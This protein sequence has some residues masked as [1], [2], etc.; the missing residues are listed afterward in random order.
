MVDV[1][2][3]L[4]AAGARRARRRAHRAA[5][6]PRPT[7]RVLW[8]HVTAS[9]VLRRRRHA[10]APAGRVEDVSERHRLRSRLRGG[11]LRRTSSPG[12]P[13]RRVAE[14][15]LHRAFAAGG[16]ARVGVCT[17][18]LD[19][20]HAD[21]RRARP[22]D[23]RP[24]AAR[25]GRAAAARGRRA[26]GHAAPAPTSSS[27]WSPSPTAPRDVSR[28]AD[29]L[30]AAL[31]PPFHDR[32]AHRRRS[33]PASGSPRRATAAAERRRAAARRR[34]RRG[35]GRRRS[36]A[37]GAWCST[38]S[39]TP[40]RRPGSRCS[41]GCAGRSTAASSG[42]STSRSCGWPT[43]GCAASRRSCAGSTPSRG[44][45]GPGRFIELAE[46]SGAIVPLGRWV[47]DGGLRAG[48]GAG[49]ASWA[50][51]RPY[52]SVNVSPGPA[53][54]AGLGARGHRR[55]GR[56]R[57]A[58]RTSSSWRSPSRRCSATRPAAA[59]R[60]DA[61]CARPASGSRSTTSAPATPA[62]PGC[63]G[64]RCTR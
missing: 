52:V 22:A 57:P 13:T 10:V 28:L 56:H 15:W 34:R 31:A 36:A 49:G 40:A 9:L 64:S 50:T 24:A 38:R 18:D 44:C 11:V 54:R 43:A 5:A 19:G 55:A 29:R 7:S 51:R 42:W 58:R 17:L 12:C 33:P 47:L 48:R 35:R 53:R 61:R 45:S 37:A 8:A 6:R 21:Q 62:S 23:R 63:A 3:R 32:R 4:P 14:Q 59:R 39:A 2:E 27:C 25:R 26:P 60:A 30:Q 1:V 16:P 20:F 46:H 41:P